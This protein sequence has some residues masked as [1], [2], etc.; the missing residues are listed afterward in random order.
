MELDTTITRIEVWADWYDPSKPPSTTSLS[1]AINQVKTGNAKIITPRKIHV[2]HKQEKSPN[3]T[4]KPTKKFKKKIIKRDKYTC[5][6]CGK[7]GY[8]IDHLIPRSAGGENSEATVYVP[9]GNVIP[10]RII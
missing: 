6:Y 2:I 9:V 7:Y 4:P 5:F 1:S 3:K 10:R 8:T